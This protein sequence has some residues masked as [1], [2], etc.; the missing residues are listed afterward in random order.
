MISQCLKSLCLGM[1]CS[2]FIELVA[3]T[4]M[5][6]SPLYGDAAKIPYILFLL[7]GALLDYVLSDVGCYQKI[8]WTFAPDGGA[9]AVFITLHV[10]A[11]LVYAV[12]FTVY[13]YARSRKWRHRTTIPLNDYFRS[14]PTMLRNTPS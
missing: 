1:S 4:C 5:A 2:I 11:M 10:N 7:T 13:C 12:V 6:L 14:P 8:L 3:M 9:S